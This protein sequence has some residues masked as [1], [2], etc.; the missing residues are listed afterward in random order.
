MAVDSIAKQKKLIAREGKPSKIKKTIKSDDGDIID[1]IDI[2][3]QPAFNHPALRNH[4]IQMTPNYSP[5]MEGRRPS[6][7]KGE[8]GSS[9]SLTS[10]LWQRSGS[11]PKGTV[12]IRRIR[13][14]KNLMKEYGRKPSLFSQQFKPLDKQNHSL[15]VL[16][17][18]GLR[19]SGVEGDIEV[20]NPFVES[21][22]DYSTSR[23]ALK[24]GDEAIQFGWA[25]NPSVYRDK[26]TRLF[27][28]WTADSSKTTGCFD[29][30]CAAFVQT[31][32][33]V[34]LGATIFPVSV[35][36]GKPYK[37]TPRIFKDSETNN[38]WV[39][40]GLI[41]IGYWPSDLFNNLLHHAETIEWGGEVYSF[42]T[43]THQPHTT[44]AMGSGYL[45]YDA[46]NMSG[47]VKQMSVA[48]INSQKEVYFKR[49]DFA[50]TYVDEYGCYGVFYIGG[51]AEEPEF[52]Y[53]G[54]GK[55]ASCP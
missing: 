25:V 11:C 33:K 52:Y 24:N 4:T 21:D 15:A 31:S 39:Q 36:G 47:C 18:N 2:Y 28:Y 22:D 46:S 43:G 37:I 29:L 45:P 51:Y 10:Q 32:N 5:T 14:G 41:H 44:T 53:G 13:V 8:G 23:V 20:H 3:K 38:W 54:S 17:T 27:V 12:P 6:S 19:Y 9:V 40:L 48:E 16:V 35:P 30:T 50:Y 34:A 42:K 1:C 55:S 26:Q 7:T 49:P